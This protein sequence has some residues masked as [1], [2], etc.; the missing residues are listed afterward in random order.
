MSASLNRKLQQA[1]DRLQA[2]DVAGTERVCRDILQQAPRNPEACW[3]LGMSQL[4][5]GRVDEG[6]ALLE[7]V[8]AVAPDHGPALEHLG[9]ARL[10]LA[11]YADA[12][13]VLRKAA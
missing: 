12:E 5:S 4:M 11:Q 2:G 10:M 8:I 13:R 9:L 6:A 7:R 3:L 1:R